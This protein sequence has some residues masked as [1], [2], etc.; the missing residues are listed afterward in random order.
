[1][2]KGTLGMQKPII[3][4]FA[5]DED[6]VASI[7]LLLCVPI[8][9]WALMSTF[10]F[11][12][13][14]RAESISTRAGLTIADMFSREE[15]NV[16][17]AYM[18]GAQALL[19]Q[20]TEAD[21]EPDLRVTAYQ[22]FENDDTTNSDDEYLVVWSQARG[23]GDTFD[24]STFALIVDRLPSLANGAVSLLVETRTE[25]TAPFRMTLNPLTETA[26]RDVEFNTFTFIAPRPIEVCY[27]ASSS[28]DELCNRIND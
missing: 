3:R 22:F 27:Q 12:D 20:L 2:T 28:S 8:L 15:D 5:D 7:E 1:M 24:D 23:Y 4:K 11:F 6:G 25:Y 14:F 21:E 13:A 17:P 26:V 18:D 10:I 16:T 9:F 19:Q